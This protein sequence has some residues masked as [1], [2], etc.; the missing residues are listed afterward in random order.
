MIAN[1]AG[2]RQWPL[3]GLPVRSGPSD[4]SADMVLDLSRLSRFGLRGTGTTAWMRAHGAPLPDTLNDSV[5]GDDLIVLR[6]GREEVLVLPRTLTGGASVDALRA[7]WD[8]TEGAKG[9]DAY[10]DE[11]WCWLRLTGPGTAAALPL[12]TAADTRDHAFPVGSVLQTRAMH[13][14]AVLLRGREGQIDI[15][16]DVASSHYARDFLADVLPGRRLARIDI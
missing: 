2:P 8:A 16:F 1:L 11:G 13:L 14:D 4:A 15:F 5:E 7:A 12:L 6:L 3:D 9:Y 10:R